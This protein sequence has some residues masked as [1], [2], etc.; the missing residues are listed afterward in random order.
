MSIIDNKYQP[1]ITAI[2]NFQRERGLNDLQFCAPAKVSSA[3]L[4]RIKS[5]GRNP[6]LRFLSALGEAYP[7]LRPVFQEALFGEVKAA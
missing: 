1:I 3:Q 7:E 5:G 4:S 2:E 6:G